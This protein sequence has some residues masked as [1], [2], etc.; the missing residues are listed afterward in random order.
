MVCILPSVSGKKLFKEQKKGMNYI[1]PKYLVISENSS[2]SDYSERIIFPL[3]KIIV[4]KKK[5]LGKRLTLAD[6]G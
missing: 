1:Y 5:K 3:Y 4:E 2:Y 6:S